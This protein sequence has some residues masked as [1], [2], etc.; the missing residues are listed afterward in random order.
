MFHL[1]DRIE[2][3]VTSHLELFKTRLFSAT[4]GQDPDEAEGN[5]SLNLVSTFESLLVE[6]QSLLI[7]ENPYKSCVALA[8]FTAAYW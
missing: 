2:Q 6:L 4:N 5:P 3:S 7:W 1:R 8:T